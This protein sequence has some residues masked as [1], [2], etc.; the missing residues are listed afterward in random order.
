MPVLS[1]GRG[2]RRREFITFLSGGGAL[3]WAVTARAEQPASN[4]PLVTLLNGTSAETGTALTP[5]FR[6]GQSQTG[7]T[8]G[9]DVDVEYHWL[10]GHYEGIS[11]ILGDDAMTQSGPICGFR[12]DPCRLILSHS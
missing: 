9:R 12:V 10:E 11:A 4:V 1:L 8:E 5:E 6:K 7:F 2:M 3:N